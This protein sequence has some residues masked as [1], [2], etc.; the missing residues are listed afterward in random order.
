MIG[1]SIMRQRDFTITEE[2]ILGEEAPSPS[3]NATYSSYNRNPVPDT[4]DDRPL[5]Y[6]SHRVEITAGNLQTVSGSMLG[7]LV[8]LDKISTTDRFC[9]SST[10]PSQRDPSCWRAFSSIFRSRD[11]R[12]SHEAL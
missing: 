12:S 10:F 3:S 5:E 2:T 7:S 4:E 8:L 11:C 6:E 9:T 1:L